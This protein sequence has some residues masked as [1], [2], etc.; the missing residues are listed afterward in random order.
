MIGEIVL[1]CKGNGMQ[2][3]ALHDTYAVGIMGFKSSFLRLR[4][5]CGKSVPELYLNASASLV[6]HMGTGV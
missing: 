1:I 3:L 4:S 5:P 6:D 2:H